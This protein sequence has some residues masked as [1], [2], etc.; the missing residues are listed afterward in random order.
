MRKSEIGFAE[1]FLTTRGMND[2]PHKAFD[3]DKAAEIIKEKLKTNPNLTAEAGLEGDWDYTGGTIFKNG[4]PT[5]EY[6][7]YLESNW[8][9]PTL[10]ITLDNGQDESFDCFTG[11]NERFSSDAKWDE[12]SLAILN[13]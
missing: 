5:T 1:G 3:W 9:M 12:I 11:A 10:I 8:A 6:Y 2:N 13:A 7:T 4:K